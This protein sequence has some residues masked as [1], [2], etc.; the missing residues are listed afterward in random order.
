MDDASG[1]QAGSVILGIDPGLNITGYGLIH[2]GHE[3]PLLLEPGL[4]RGGSPTPIEQR[5]EKIHDGVSEVIRQHRPMA[6]AV[7]ELYSNYRMPRTAILMGHARGVICLAASQ[8]G[9]PVFHYAAT[10]VKKVLTG[11]GRASKEQMQD[12]ISRE[13]GLATAPEPAD[14]ADALAIALCHH[15]LGWNTR[16][17]NAC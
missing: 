9:I 8:H 17:G 11:N 12:A 6:I 1:R 2:V 5:L 15:Y 16:L 4:V 10:Q 3:N 14:V 7:E 13:F